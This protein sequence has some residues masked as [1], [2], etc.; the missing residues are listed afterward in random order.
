MSNKNWI[1]CCGLG[2]EYRGAF[3]TLEEA[4]QYVAANIVRPRENYNFEWRC[5]MDSSGVI[6]YYSWN[7]AVRKM[8]AEEADAKRSEFG[9]MPKKKVDAIIKGWLDSGVIT[10]DE[11]ATRNRCEFPQEFVP[12]V[13]VTHVHRERQYLARSDSAGNDNTK[14]WEAFAKLLG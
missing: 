5:Q 6:D 8:T 13:A 2:A 9:S 14:R 4:I 12:N 11:A 10:D 7:C 1:V 3:N